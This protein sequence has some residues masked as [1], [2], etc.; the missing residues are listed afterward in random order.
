MVGEPMRVHGLSGRR[1]SA[2]RVRELL[3]TVGLPADAASRYP[4]EFS[5]GQRQRIGV[6]RA[7]ALNPDFIVAD[8][9]VSAL[10][11]SIQ[12]QIINLLDELQDDFGL[13]YLFVA[14]D[15]S[16]VRHVSDRIAVMYLG[17]IMEL[18]PSEEL[19]TKPIH[20]YTA[21]LLSAIP[22][23][24]PE[25]NRKRERIVVGGEPPSPVDPPSGCVFHT[26]CPRAQD[27]CRQEVPRLSEYPNGHLAACHFPLNVTREEVAASTKS[28]LSPLS[29]GDTQ[30]TVVDA[31][32]PAA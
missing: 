29:S 12:A 10:D 4:H 17:K 25:L 30:P 14:H 9:P 3:Q 2:Q 26:R 18:S 21:A 19:Y 16:V 27:L 7:L 24:D 20:P 1:A 8:E 6:A 23:P 5:G 32:A 11:V 31:G 22:V 15:L 28:P 13:T